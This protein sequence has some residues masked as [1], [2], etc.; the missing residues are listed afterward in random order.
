MRGIGAKPSAA[1]R[2]FRKN[3]Y[4]S[5]IWITFRMLLEPFERTKFLRFK[6][7]LKKF[8][9]RFS[10]YSEVLVLKHV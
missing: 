10:L 4:F 2:F 6:S 5:A 9:V 7:Q 3:S 1:G 8:I